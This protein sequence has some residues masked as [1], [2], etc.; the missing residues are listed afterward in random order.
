MSQMSD[1]QADLLAVKTAMQGGDYETARDLLLIAR[2]SLA[3]IPDTQMSTGNFRFRLNE[4]DGLEK[5]IDD[6][7]RRSTGTLTRISTFYGPPERC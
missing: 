1:Y 7:I 4:L 5:S 3:A 6:K 2:T